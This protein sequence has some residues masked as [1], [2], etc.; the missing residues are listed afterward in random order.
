MN[1]PY[2]KVTVFG[3]SGFVGRYV[4]QKLAKTGAQVVVPARNIE[5]AKFLKPLG[6]VG[7]IVPVWCNAQD[8]A[9]IASAVRG[10]DAAINLIGVLYEKGRQ[11]FQAMHV[12][13]AKHIAQA[14]QDAG[15]KSLVHVSALGA[16]KNS[17]AAYARSKAMGEE[18]VLKTFPS[19]TILRPSVIFGPEDNFFNMFA[20][21]ARIVPIIPLIGGGKTKFQPVYVGDVAEAV[22]CALRD[23]TCRGRI[24]SLGGPEVRNFAELM[25]I[26]LGHTKQKAVMMSV[27]FA[28]ARIKAAFLQM[29]PKPLLT[30]D[31]LRLLEKDNIVPEGSLGFKDLGIAPLQMDAILPQYLGQYRPGGKFAGLAA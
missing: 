15:C 13:A 3:G 17:N 14:A 22:L 21:L 4:V 6:D 2:S 1:F 18:E 16:D 5:H 28:M 10:S 25:Q 20:S 24:Y 27:P 29:M 26:M 19:A 11:N 31:Q 8:K 7:Q 30:L 23:P 9:Q 12:E